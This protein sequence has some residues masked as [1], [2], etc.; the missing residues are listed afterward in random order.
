MADGYRLFKF[1]LPQRSRLRRRD[2][3]AMVQSAV[4][5]LPLQRLLKHRMCLFLQF[6]CHE[7]RT[8]LNRLHRVPVTYGVH[9]CIFCSLHTRKHIGVELS[10]RNGIYCN[11]L[12]DR[13]L[14]E[15]SDAG[16]HVCNGNRERRLKSIWKAVKERYY[17]HASIGTEEREL[18]ARHVKHMRSANRWL[19]KLKRCGDVKCLHTQIHRSDAG[20]CSPNPGPLLPRI[21][22]GPYTNNEGNDHRNC[23]QSCRQHSS[24]CGYSGPVHVAAGACLEARHVARSSRH[25]I[26]PRLVTVN[27]AMEPRHA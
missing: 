9:Q 19:Q 3:A 1:P 2:R 11:P 15:C 25:S 10:R 22:N 13:D 12:R 20:L 7:S 14:C 8:W 17:A 4:I 21:E 6:F 27:S 23:R 24:N 26:S 5:G 16:P 18:R